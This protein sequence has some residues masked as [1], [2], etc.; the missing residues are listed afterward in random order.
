VVQTDAKANQ[1][2]EAIADHE[3]VKAAALLDESGEIERLE[4]RAK[5]FRSGVPFDTEDSA[6]GDGD[7]EDVFIESVVDRYLVV[8]FEAGLEF[9]LIKAEV[10]DLLEKLEL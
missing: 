3:K 5:V 9:E 10:D 7:H 6:E 1:L 4:G 2:V 8:V